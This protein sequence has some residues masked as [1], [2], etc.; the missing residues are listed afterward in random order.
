MD[1][2][3]NFGMYGMKIFMGEFFNLVV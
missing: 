2:H 1:N 3:L